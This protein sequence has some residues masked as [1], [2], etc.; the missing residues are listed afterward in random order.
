[1]RIYDAVGCPRCFGTGYLGRMGIFEVLALD[2]EMG[3]MIER[4][5]PVREL[6][7]AA[8]ASGVESARDDG[9]RKVL[10]GETSLSE[11]T[12]VVI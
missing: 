4:G 2:E 10:A 8:R 12:R 7:E 1:M 5:V 9:V 6:R 3:D 11:L